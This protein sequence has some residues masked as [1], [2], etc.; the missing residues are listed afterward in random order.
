M[1]EKTRG[2][3][4]AGGA[5]MIMLGAFATWKSTSYD[6][7]SLTDMG[8][9]F[10][11]ALV[12]I[13]LGLTGVGIMLRPKRGE[14]ERAP[15]VEGGSERIDWRGWLFILAGIA[16]FIVVAKQAGLLPATFAIVFISAFGDRTNTLKSATILA[17]AIS[18]V[19]V[20]VFWWA[21]QVQLPLLKWGSSI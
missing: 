21:L 18:V 2:R 15:K 17:L 5:L 10:Y 20:V 3:D 1:I 7:G 4:Y 8:P 6:I 13:L 9:G 12:G 11:P 19:S 14:A 16:S